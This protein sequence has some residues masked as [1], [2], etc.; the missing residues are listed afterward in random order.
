M[1]ALTPDLD[2]EEVLLMVLALLPCSCFALLTLET[3]NVDVMTKNSRDRCSANK[4]VSQQPTNKQQPLCGAALLFWWS[5][6]TLIF[7]IL[8]DFIMFLSMEHGSGP[9]T[10]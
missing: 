9:R 6:P 3:N 5:T 10:F 8:F 1:F 2:V 4:L 7:I